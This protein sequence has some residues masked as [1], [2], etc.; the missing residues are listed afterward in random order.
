MKPAAE[1][2]N[3][4]YLARARERMR[5][6][7]SLSPDVRQLV[8][9]HGWTVVNAFLKLGVTKAKHIRHLIQ[10]VKNGSDAYGNGTR[11]VKRLELV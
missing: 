10:T 5:Q 6:I 1:G 4:E 7:D 3:E 8:H 2:P 9:E 11:G